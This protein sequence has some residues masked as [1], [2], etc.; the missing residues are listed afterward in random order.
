MSAS[1]AITRHTP[2]TLRPTKATCDPD[3]TIV[4]AHPFGY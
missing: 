3:R 2:E 1:N 4:S